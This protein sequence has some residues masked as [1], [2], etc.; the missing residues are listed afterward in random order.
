MRYQ[1]DAKVGESGR[2]HVTSVPH[3][4]LARAGAGS[5]LHRAVDT[6]YDQRPV[7]LRTTRYTNL[8][9]ARGDAGYAAGRARFLRTVALLNRVDGLVFPEVLD[10]FSDRNITEPFSDG[11]LQVTEPV[12]VFQEIAGTDLEDLLGRAYFVSVRDGEDALPHRIHV[13]RVAR[14]MRRVTLLAQALLNAGVAHV[15]LRPSHVL[16]MPRDEVP[17]LLGVGHLVPLD[18][19]ALGEDDPAARFTSLGFA[20]PEL[21][22]PSS[23]WG[24][25]ASGEA[26]M[27]YG[28]G[29]TLLA[30]AAGGSDALVDRYAADGPDGLLALLA[31][32]RATTSA[33]RAA[34]SNHRVQYLDLVAELLQIEPEARLARQTLDSLAV[35]LEVLAGDRLADALSDLACEKCGSAFRG[36]P[37]RHAFDYGGRSFVMCRACLRTANTKVV[38]TADRCGCS[39]SERTGCAWAREQLGQSP[40]VWCRTHRPVR[41]GG[42]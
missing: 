8:E 29:A 3:G 40:R 37:E 35:A 15:D 11:S 19:G 28:I 5:N 1:R 36:D 39:Y 10:R 38:R 24:A 26:V 7:T 17:R 16:L 20:A 6:R 25:G 14:M 22:S 13:S 2:F 18:G 21:V 31:E 34:H 41:G 4:L 30:I 12:L 42:T 27:L 23:D 32:L 9:F 33:D